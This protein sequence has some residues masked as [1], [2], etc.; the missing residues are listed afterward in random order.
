MSEPA[1][2]QVPV[3]SAGGAGGW[4]VRGARNGDVAAVAD[5]VR[6]LLLELGGTP[7]PA[8]AMR[9]TVQDLLDSPR[10]GAVIVAECATGL[11]GV[12]GASWQLAIH[13][14]GRY[15]LIQELWVDPAW[16]GRAIG[17]A[18]LSAL[19]ELARARRLEVI[20][21]GLPRASFAGLAATEAFYRANGF[22]A[23]GPRMRLLLS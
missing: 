3:A 5:A 1:R 20:E 6:E 22:L 19:S 15:A 13:V 8:R 23:L 9:A 16:R 17:G 2:S 10:A 18:M 12:L 14:P 21:V 11:V 7:A 4:L